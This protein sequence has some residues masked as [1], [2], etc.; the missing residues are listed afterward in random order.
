MDYEYRVIAWIDNDPDTKVEFTFYFPNNARELAL[1]LRDK[2]GYNRVHI[3]QLT[4]ETIELWE[5][6]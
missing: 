1:K 4:V 3:Q 5:S 2:H 6:K